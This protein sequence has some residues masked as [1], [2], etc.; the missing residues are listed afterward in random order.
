M[1][2][3][4][5]GYRIRRNSPWFKARRKD[6]LMY[7]QR[8]PAHIYLCLLRKEYSEKKERLLKIVIMNIRN[9]TK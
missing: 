5:L 3:P 6:H 2:F 8:K 7:V 9:A 4:S 1:A